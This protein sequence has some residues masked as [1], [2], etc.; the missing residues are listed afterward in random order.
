MGGI[1]RKMKFTSGGKEL[2]LIGHIVDI[3]AEIGTSEVKTN[4]DFPPWVIDVETELHERGTGQAFWRTIIGSYMKGMG[5]TEQMLRVDDGKDLSLKS[6]CDSVLCSVSHEAQ[7]KAQ[8][9]GFWNYAYLA[10]SRRRFCITRDGR[11]G[12]VLGG[13]VHS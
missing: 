5:T 8:I 13:V 7:T 12:L 6:G 1:D 2:C 9:Q 4:D 11:F 10:C 3:L